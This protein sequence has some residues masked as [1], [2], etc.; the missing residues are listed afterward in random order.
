MP[1]RTS[2]LQAST[3]RASS[4]VKRMHFCFTSASAPLYAAPGHLT[5]QTRG[6]VILRLRTRKASD[7]IDIVLSSSLSQEQS[8]SSSSRQN[9][10][11]S[12][13]G[14]SRASFS[15]SVSSTVFRK[16]SSHDTNL[17]SHTGYEHKWAVILKLFA[18]RQSRYG[19]TLRKRAT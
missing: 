17:M 11:N 4:F 18:F 7:A 8:Y 2:R 13:S 19:N 1:A 10:A 15:G 6:L 3:A 14:T 9:M 5:I 12:T 16:I